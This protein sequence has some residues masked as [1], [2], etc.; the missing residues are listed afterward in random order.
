M[1]KILFL[2]YLVWA[3]RLWRNAFAK[4]LGWERRGA[5]SFVLGAFAHL[6]LFG[7]LSAIFVVWYRITPFVVFGILAVAGAI[8]F[9]ANRR[10]V[11]LPAQHPVADDS[12]PARPLQKSRSLFFLFFIVLVAAAALLFSRQSSA[13]L[14]SPWQAIDGW[15]LPVFFILTAVLGFLLFS[16]LPHRAILLTIIAYSVIQH[17]YLPAAHELPWGGDVWRHTAVEQRLLEQKFYPPVLFGTEAKYHLLR[18]AYYEISLPEALLIPNKYAYGYLWGTT[19]LLAQALGIDLLSLNRWLGPITFGVMFPILL[20]RLGVILFKSRR[21]ALW[22]ATLSALPFPL[23]SLGALTLPVSLG[24]LTFIFAL[25]VWFSLPPSHRARRLFFA[26]SGLF[27]FGYTL[28]A[29]LLWFLLAIRRPSLEKRVWE[30]L[31]ISIGIVFFPVIEFFAGTSRWPESWDAWRAVKQAIGQFSG[32]FFASLIR[33]HDI[34]SAN[35]VFNHLPFQAFTPSIFLSWRWWIIPALAALWGTAFYGALK[36]WREGDWRWRAFAFFGSTALGG[37][38]VGW[39]FLEGERLFVRRL[40]ALLAVLLIVFFL[41]GVQSIVSK[42]YTLISIPYTLVVFLFAWF[43]TATYASG[44]DLRVV[45]RDEYRAAEFIW[46]VEKPREKHCVVADT[47]LLLAL[48]GISERAVVGGGFPIDRNFGQKERV[49]LL[50][51][52][53]SNP[54]PELL[55]AAKEKTGADRCSVALDAGAVSEIVRDKLTYIFRAEP[56]RLGGALVWQE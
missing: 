5:P 1:M 38:L 10:A 22:L 12:V 8:A 31:K 52:M 49:E 7:L 19:T 3:G 24:L 47:W 51:E 53:I 32:W 46:E 14:L 26:F 54:R 40:D 33:P 4:A 16:K 39:Y 42:P 29:L 25:D 43:T 48:E 9:F 37:Y 20:E 2:A 30:W 35:L 28:Y 41:K 17:F 56:A 11:S 45:S 27:V 6:L 18:I 55:A 50:K 44:P 13:V 34:P 21:Y 23:Q 15:Y 36:A